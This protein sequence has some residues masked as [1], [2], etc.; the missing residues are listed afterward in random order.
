M[1]VVILLLALGLPTGASAQTAV[2][3]SSRVTLAPWW[4]NA[5][6]T[7]S[8]GAAEV[9][10]RANRASID[11]SFQVV[12]T[13]SAE[14]TRVAAEKI[15]NLAAQLRAFGAEKARVETSFY[16]EPIYEQYRDKAGTLN[17]N[18]RADKIERYK[19][20]VSIGI[21]I[22]DLTVLEDVY[23]TVLA[24]RPTR[25]GQVRFSLEA[26]SAATTALQRSAVADG[27]E[28]ARRAAQATGSEL[29]PVKLIDPSGQACSSAN[30]LAAPP[31]DE[32]SSSARMK[33]AATPVD[34]IV[35]D[36]IV[37]G[38]RA[39][40]APPELRPEDMRLPLQP[41]L[42]TLSSQACVVFALVAK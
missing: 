41:P 18:E 5:P 23:S 4:M 22:R 13:S 42:I 8:I 3:A 40:T 27:R 2:P 32:V 29:G 21:E 14:A 7:P 30:L 17:D 37:V 33:R 6:V 9:R 39:R 36:D 38:A 1:R 19:V 31:P 20:E 11:A 16:M 26:D 12:D 15:T 10:L 24:S 35:A 28:R 25:T 34:S